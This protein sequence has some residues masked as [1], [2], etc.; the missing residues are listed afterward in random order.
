MKDRGLTHLGD[1]GLTIGARQENTEVASGWMNF[2]M[3]PMWLLSGSFFS[4]TRFPE[5]T[6]PLIKLLPLTAL[7]DGLRG[8]YNHAETVMDLAPEAGVLLAWGV[9]CFIIALRRFRWQ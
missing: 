3:L 8:I 2:V 6:H 5:I 1:I 7:N 9:G 4:Y